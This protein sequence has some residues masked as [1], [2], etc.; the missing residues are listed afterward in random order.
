[1]SMLQNCRENKTTALAFFQIATELLK[2]HSIACE[3]VNLKMISTRYGLNRTHIYEKKEQIEKAAAQMVLAGKGRPTHFIS[4]SGIVSDGQPGLKLRIVILEHR[5][6]HPGALVV[7]KSGRATYSDGFK[8]HILDQDDGW[9]GTDEEFCA[10]SS[11]PLPTRAPLLPCVG[12]LNPM[13][14][15]EK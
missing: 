9:K 2:H 7:H 8:R 1:M 3:K 11:I 6:A 12:P 10:A 4:K 15:R 13:R 14:F 5:L